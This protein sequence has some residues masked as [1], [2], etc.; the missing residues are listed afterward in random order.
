[1]G[2]A[3]ALPLLAAGR[4]AGLRSARGWGWGPLCARVDTQTGGLTEDSVGDA[5]APARRAAGCRGPAREKGICEGHPPR[6]GGLGCALLRDL[7]QVTCPLGVSLS[8]A[9][10]CGGQAMRTDTNNQA[11]GPSI[12]GPSPFGS[13]TSS[14]Y[15]STLRC[16]FF[17]GKWGYESYLPYKV[18]RNPGRSFTENI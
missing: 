16:L 15:F 12:P 13:V 9:G 11:L 5:R 2:R 7:G 6:S 8:P 18:V 14:H 17:T 10:Q 3:Q 4:G 1:M